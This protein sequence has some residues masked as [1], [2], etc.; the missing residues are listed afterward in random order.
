MPVFDG[1][2]TSAD[3]PVGANALRVLTGEP[4]HLGVGVQA[5]VTVP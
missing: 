5:T 3:T 1:W 2:C 4:A